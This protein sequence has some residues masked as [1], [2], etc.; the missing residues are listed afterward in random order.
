ME[1]EDTPSSP[2][3]T[4]SGGESVST[5]MPQVKDACKE[6]ERLSVTAPECDSQPCGD[7]VPGSSLSVST[8]LPYTTPAI[9]NLTEQETEDPPDTSTEDS[10]NAVQ[11]PA[12]KPGDIASGLLS[13]SASSLT[14]TKEIGPTSSESS[15]QVRCPVSKQSASERN[16]DMTQSLSGRPDDKTD[17]S[18]SHQGKLSIDD[19]HTAREGATSHDQRDSTAGQTPKHC[20]SVAKQFASEQDK[21]KTI[22]HDT[23]NVFARPDDY[24][25]HI[26]TEQHEL[27]KLVFRKEDQAAR[28]EKCCSDN[29]NTKQVEYSADP[30][31]GPKE[32]ARNTEVVISEI[33]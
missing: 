2:N 21:G 1:K 26:N 15:P 24:E 12:D 6:E 31:P 13:T 11:I 30:C 7:A 28:D 14:S 22:S 32:L 23:E 27:V 19:I 8:I 18:D 9:D 29:Q 25:N 20:D 5:A 17:Y 33:H 16:T 10:P 3:L 4:F